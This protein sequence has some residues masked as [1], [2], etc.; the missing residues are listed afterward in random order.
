MKS[1]FLGAAPL[2]N[3]GG[4]KSNSLPPVPRAG[5][6]DML[7][8]GDTLFV[9]LLLASIMSAHYNFHIHL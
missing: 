1:Y 8:L 2:M 6:I 3:V 5:E 4:H 9:Y 7:N